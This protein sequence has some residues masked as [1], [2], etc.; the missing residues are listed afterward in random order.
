LKDRKQMFFETKSLN[1][2]SGELLAYGSLLMEGKEVRLSGQDVERG[3]FS[4]RHAVL[5]DAASSEPYCNLSHL[6]SKQADFMI[7]NS[8]LSEYGVLG[9]E[10]GYSMAN[11]DALVIW[12][13]QFGDFGNGA[14]VM[15]D[16]FISCSE[17]KWQR[18][19]G[20][21]MLLPHGYEGQGPE[22]SSARL[23][24][25]LQLSAEY[26]MV[27][28]NVT[29]PA[30]IFHLLRRQL[31]WPFRKPLVVMSPKS[32]LRHPLC[33]S[34]MEEFTTGKFHEVIPDTYAKADKVKKVLLCSGKFYW[35]LF[36][37]Q[38][39][40]KRED[41]AIIRIEQIHPFPT[42]QVEATLAQYKNAKLFWVQE[43]PENM[44]S[45]AYLLR[46]FRSKAYEIISRRTS[47]SP[48]T[49]YAKKHAEEQANIIKRAFEL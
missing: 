29:T 19:N 22:H 11:P 6:D 45:W 1:W 25:F 15:I 33:V 3:T 12:E 26:N 23:E 28:A 2:A 9:F 30:N 20:L 13:A 42:E 47:A 17:T 8:L 10:F 14:Q 49:G 38:Q 27:V 34:P 43:E 41:I 4:H 31:T 18:M 46:S 16:Q 24:R 36:Q 35:E 48:A 37:E 40:K 7:Y 44:G 21:V 39:E 32:M 5:H